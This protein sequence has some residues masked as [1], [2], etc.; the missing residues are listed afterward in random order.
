MPHISWTRLAGLLAIFT[1]SQA[2]HAQHA[3]AHAA[4][5]PLPAQS[6]IFERPAQRFTESSPVGTGRLGAMDFGGIDNARLV[7]N[8]NSMWSGRPLDQNRKDAWKN[9]EKIIALL[10]E[11]QNPEAEELVNQTFTS[12]GPG[13][14]HGNG[15]D[16]PFGCYQ[17]LGA[18][19]L[20]MPTLKSPSANYKRWLDVM[21]GSAVTVATIDGYTYQREVLASHAH[22]V[23][24]VRISTDAPEG[25]RLRAS[26]SRGERGDSSIDGP[27]L[28]LRGALNDGTGGDGVAYEGRVRIIA[29]TAPRAR[30]NGLEVAGDRDILLLYAARTSYA[31][32][33]KVVSHGEN[34]AQA[35]RDDLDRA[36]K[37]GADPAAIFQ[38]LERTSDHA[39][40]MN[41]VQLHLGAAPAG[42][43]QARL[44]ELEKGASDPA[45]AALLFQFGRHL[46]I[47]SSRQGGLPANLQG[48]WAE[49]LQ[50]PWNGDYHAN[51]NVQMNYWPVHTTGLADCQ[52][53][54]TNL[55]EN[56]V[57]PGQRTARAYYDAPG[58][59]THVITNVWGYT[60]PGEHASWGSTLS[61]GAWLCDH[62]WEH[63]DYT[64]DRAYLER[65]Y[66]TLRLACEF[67]RSILVELPGSGWLVTG[68]SNSPENA[69]KMKD[70]RVAHTC[71]GPTMD[72]QLLRE[73]FTN[74]IQAAEILG[75]DDAWRQDLA[76]VRDRLAPTQVGPDGRLMEWLEPYEEPEP[77]H[78]HVSHLYGLYPGS[79]ITLYGTPAL[80][81]A[82]RRTLEARGD[83]STG[84]SMAWKACF[85]AR[86]GDGDRAEALIRQALRPVVDAGF[87][88]RDG[89]GSY[90]NLFGA[91][92]P[93]Q[94]D[95]N[96]GLTAAIAEMLLQSHAEKPGE[97]PT[98]N[99]LPA[100][101]K[102]WPTGSITGLCA[103]G[104]Y[105]V[106]I[107]WDQG[108]LTRASIERTH[109]AA[110]AEVLLRLP[111]RT[112]RRLITFEKGATRV[113]ID[114]GVLPGVAA[115]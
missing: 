33:I 47:G 83:R 16:G 9:R 58:W 73:L 78:R 112:D 75:K 55:I 96:F 7:L 5:E 37:L 3:A 32:P 10:L 6:I 98:L 81:Q 48:L 86:L 92:P 84:W 107:A 15:K 4:A 50:T 53:P 67:Y 102:A 93:F 91:H 25:L 97:R 46:L 20:A 26:L 74:S 110:D 64:L 60:A 8:E 34:Y 41:R 104:G 51:I 82:A 59:V 2:A 99:L 109:P 68:P 30:D 54:L 36:Q 28:V 21:T 88:Y 27:D 43:A 62:L 29:P 61:G 66:P 39:S 85:W 111:G 113:E 100:L 94:I 31:G 23:I 105:R 14:S 115:P 44:V 13:S 57:S 103:R 12:D 42:S 70:G 17:V 11:G 77:R 71:L 63:Y 79:E 45:L 19:E 65:I 89:G 49:E 72:Q 76:K 24:A 40:L 35:V 106:D 95:S 1:A 69:F 56:L 90:P 38:E 101:P 80:A 52:E 114:P 87:N 108:S 18:L 22:D